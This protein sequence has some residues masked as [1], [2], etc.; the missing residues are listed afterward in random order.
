MEHFN[1]YSP[2]LALTVIS[3][4]SIGIA[5][6]VA[7]WVAVDI[8]LR[9]GWR[10]MMGVMIPVYI[11]NALYLWPITLWVYLQYGRPPKPKPELKA[12]PSCH[13]ETRINDVPPDSIIQEGPNTCCSK[14]QTKKPSCHQQEQQHGKTCH[15]EEG[16]QQKACHSQK[17]QEVKGR[18]GQ[19]QSDEGCCSKKAKIFEK[20]EPQQQPMRQDSNSTSSDLEK[21][22]ELQV[23]ACHQ[24]AAKR[25]LFAILT[26]AVCHCGADCVLG[27]IIGE[28][29]VYGTG[30]TI[31]GRGLW[32]AYLVDF[33][34]AI[35]F[36]LVFQYFSIAPMSGDYSLKTLY[37]ALKADF[38]SLLF[39]EIGLFGWMAI[40]Q[41]AIFDWKLEMNTVT[42]WWMMQIGMFMGHWTGIPI[43]WLLM[44]KGIKEPC[45]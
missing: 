10:T 29:L 11:V 18:T 30:A 17:K 33:A 6:V 9:R 35:A 42:Y 5:A 24:H 45:C 14:N 4:I 27:D 37:R 16:Q 15:D 19:E 25:P 43:N 28:W 12:R 21:V 38:F 34:F 36:G 3:S 7:L 32:V 8:I 22:G 39:F 26:A 2:P 31:A 40:F 41:I 44:K 1:H 13:A 20:D 23:H